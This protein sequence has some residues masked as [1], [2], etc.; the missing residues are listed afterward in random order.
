MP[1]AL[2]SEGV[3]VCSKKGPQASDWWPGN[4][5]RPSAREAKPSR[6]TS[7]SR[8]GGFGAT[9]LGFGLN[10]QAAQPD[11]ILLLLFLSSHPT[12]SRAFSCSIPPRC[13]SFTPSPHSSSASHTEDQSRPG[14]RQCVT[15]GTFDSLLS[16]RAGVCSNRSIDTCFT[17]GSR[18]NLHFLLPLL[19][20]SPPSPVPHDNP[21]ARQS[22]R[23]SRS[24]RQPSPKYSTNDRRNP[25]SRIRS[26]CKSQERY[27]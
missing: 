18:Q 27:T 4:Q 7:L 25:Q 17:H 24:T 1:E 11:Q 10:S 16:Y 13:L 9:N 22:P 2:A 15:L 26:A 14:A 3:C 20:P 12:E 23:H 21:I 19:V 5:L 8:L 6:P